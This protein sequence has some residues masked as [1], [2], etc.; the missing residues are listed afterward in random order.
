MSNLFAILA[1]AQNKIEGDLT[2][3]KLKLFASIVFTAFGRA[4]SA[5]LN[6]PV[7]T[8]E[9][10]SSSSLEHWKIILMKLIEFRFMFSIWPKY[11]FKMV[12]DLRMNS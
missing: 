11:S 12:F 9:I 6:I 1:L 3:R 10:G 2:W 7:L 4:F 8:R 5:R